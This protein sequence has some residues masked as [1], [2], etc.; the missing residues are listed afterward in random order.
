MVECLLMIDLGRPL[1]AIELECGISP[2]HSCFSILF[3]FVGRH[4][5]NLLRRTIRSLNRACK[6]TCEVVDQ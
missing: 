6:A 4:E 2:F 3:L 1:V 5:S